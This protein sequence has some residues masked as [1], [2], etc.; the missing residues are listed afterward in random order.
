LPFQLPLVIN[1]A[2]CYYSFNHLFG[3]TADTHLQRA[4]SPKPDL[5]HRLP[6]DRTGDGRDA[7][8][9]HVTQDVFT[10]LTFVILALPRCTPLPR[11]PHAPPSSKDDTASF[12]F[13]LS[14]SRF[15]FPF[16]VFFSRLS[17]SSSS[18]SSTTKSDSYAS[19]SSPV[20][21]PHMED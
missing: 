2:S 14:C 1:S 9:G 6:L 19:R 17:S 3:W 20:V 4:R 12:F 7:E 16:L 15:P 10:A 18:S 13:R 5:C 11:R 21:V 8:G